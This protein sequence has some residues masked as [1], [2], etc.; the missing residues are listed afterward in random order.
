MRLLFQ[1][2]DL[3]TLLQWVSLQW[4]Y[5]GLAAV[6]VLFFLIVRFGGPGLPRWA[7]ERTVLSVSRIV[8]LVTWA[9]AILRLGYGPPG[10]VLSTLLPYGEAVSFAGGI[11]AFVLPFWVMMADFQLE[12]VVRSVFPRGVLSR[13]PTIRALL[14]AIKIPDEATCETAYKLAKDSTSHVKAAKRL[15]RKGT[16][17]ESIS[18]L[19][20][21]VEASTKSMGLLLGT[22]PNDPDI[23]E[24]KVSHH[25][26]KAL[27]LDVDPLRTTL[28]NL[29]EVYA[30][31]NSA[32]NLPK[33]ISGQF[34][35][36]DKAVQDFGKDMLAPL[37]AIAQEAHEIRNLRDEDMWEPTLNLDRT[38][39]WV[40]KALTGLAARPVVGKT[41]MSIV[42]FTSSALDIAGFMEKPDSLKF[43]FSNGLGEAFQGA[44]WLAVLLDWHFIPSRYS[45]I[46]ASEHWT[47][48]AYTPDR[49]LVRE[50][51]RLFVYASSL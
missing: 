10:N 37:D 31:M 35:R 44:L 30:N 22:L 25:A 3:A 26:S 51:P 42:S 12:R 23:I 9:Y 15:Y 17:A 39:Q 28:A 41:T 45:P 50:A 1:N 29:K 18:W 43:R 48:D 20:Q 33:S 34:R 36:F 11:V 27:L 8:I 38:N 16:Y 5:I 6:S 4:V 2:R 14:D 13:N 24:N 19:Q 46:R 21:A 7:F 47:A 49:P 40:D 32:D